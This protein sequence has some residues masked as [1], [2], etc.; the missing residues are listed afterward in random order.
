MTKNTLL[1]EPSSLLHYGRI[2]LPMAIRRGACAQACLVQDWAAM[3]R[4]AQHAI[5]RWSENGDWLSASVALVHLG[6]DTLKAS[7]PLLARKYYDRARQF[8]SW[9][10]SPTQR[11][12]EAAALYGVSL[13]EI[14]LASTAEAID[15]AMER[16][17]DAYQLLAR[18]RR[19]WIVQPSGRAQ[20]ARCEEAARR[21]RSTVAKWVE[22][23][24][25]G[26]RYCCGSRAVS[27]S[28][29]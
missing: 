29:M 5:E 17:E 12:N 20:I 3:E 13:A 4:I 15:V 8:F 14:A 27:I 11:Q 9:R 10:V 7:N 24:D 1:F 19:D 22:M 2:N 23:G 25:G 21:M 26:S 28:M 16:L 6:D 18:A